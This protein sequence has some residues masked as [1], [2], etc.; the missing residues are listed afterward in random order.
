MTRPEEWAGKVAERR[1]LITSE[2]IDRFVAL[3]GD[4]SSIHVDDGFART[5]G[6]RSRIAH[7]L[8]IGS[9]ISALVGTELPGHAGVLQHVNFSFRNPCY[10][11]DCLHLR[12]EVDE[13]IESVQTLILKVVVRNQ[14]GLT[15]ATGKIQAGFSTEK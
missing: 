11:G 7:G 13:F 1:V 2:L 12:L 14:D 5:R 15:V 8:L 10:P 6:F 4:N 9:L 3:S